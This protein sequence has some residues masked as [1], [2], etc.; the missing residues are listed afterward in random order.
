MYLWVQLHVR[1]MHHHVSTD[2][3]KTSREDVGR[4][5]FYSYACQRGLQT[6]QRAMLTYV[7]MYTHL[8]TLTPASSRC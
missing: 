3:Y 4:G 8:R 5:N 6:L 1:T 2:S 7:R